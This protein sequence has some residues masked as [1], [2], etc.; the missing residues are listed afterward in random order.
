VSKLE[1]K[2][3]PIALVVFT[4]ALMWLV[5]RYLPS[6]VFFFPGRVPVAL[7]FIIAGLIVSVLGVVQFRRAGTT[8]NPVTPHSA[9][10]L[11]VS[12]IYRFTR[13]PMYLGFLLILVGWGIFLANALSFL[14]L[15]IFVAYLTRFQIKPEEQALSRAFGAAFTDYKSKV[16]R[17]L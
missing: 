10:S 15:P 14:L 7:G 9:S 11:V 1:L 13:N 2:L 17:W 4:S 16:R 5:A 6:L 3:P 12:G 8:V